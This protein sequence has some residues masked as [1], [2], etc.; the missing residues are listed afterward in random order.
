MRTR[1]R[2]ERGAALLETAITLPIILLI[3]VGIF[4]FG[5]AYQTWQVITNASR[6]GA[7]VAVIIGTPEAKVKEAVIAYAKIGGIPECP[8]DKGVTCI[9]PSHITLTT[10]EINDRSYSQIDVGLPFNFMVLNGIAKLVTSGSTLGEPLTMTARSLMRN[11]GA[12]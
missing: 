12:S 7:R 4:E 3:C 8:A 11:E 9:D 10:V 1:M 5:R 2:N 6:E